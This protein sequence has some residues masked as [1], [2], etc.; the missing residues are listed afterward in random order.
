MGFVMFAE[1]PRVI[2]H[3]SFFFVWAATCFS[4]QRMPMGGWKWPSGSS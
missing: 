2:V 3:P 1:R 4:T